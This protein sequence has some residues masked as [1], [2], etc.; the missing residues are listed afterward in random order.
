MKKRRYKNG[1]AEF[2]LESLSDALVRVTHREQKGHIGI[3]KNWDAAKP[4]TWTYLVPG[5]GLEGTAKPD[6]IEG[7]PFSHATPEEALIFLCK[8][9]LDLQ[10]KEDSRRINPEERK[11][12]ARQVLREFLEGLPE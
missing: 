10:S 8:I 1:R 9:L 5:G 4:Y 12:V 3:S 6:G 11:L 7:N 2:T